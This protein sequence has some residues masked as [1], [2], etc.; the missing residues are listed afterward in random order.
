[1]AKTNGRT[2]KANIEKTLEKILEKAIEARPPKE[3]KPTEKK[4]YYWEF[5]LYPDCPRHL[6]YYFDIKQGKYQGCTGCVHD[7]DITEATPERF[8]D[9]GNYI[10]AEPPHLKKAHA[11]IIVKLPFEG[12]K[13]S[14]ERLFPNLESHLIMRVDCADERY[15]Y[16]IHLDDPKKHRYSPNEVFGNTENFYRYYHAESEA[17]EGAE[18]CRILD[19]LDNW[20]Y[21]Q[22]KPTYTKVIRICA[23][24][25][26]YGY[27]RAGGV[28]LSQA[29]KE[30]IDEYI[31]EYNDYRNLE[32]NYIKST[33]ADE[34]WK[35]NAALKSANNTIDVYKRLVK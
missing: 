24:L 8:D 17:Y 35:L 22:G 32:D 27:L 1:M 21:T 6:E 15:R 3:K 31:T 2:K 13:G 18:I 12:T 34:I 9:N 16:L 14:V 23:E 4:S 33:Q 28:L 19:I 7:K 10:P 26:L 25:G 30:A 20:D 29:I 11:H 5:I